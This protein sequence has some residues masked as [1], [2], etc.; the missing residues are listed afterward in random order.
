MNRE[1]V[2]RQVVSA[3]ELV[4]SHHNVQISSNK[5]QELT[6]LLNT[7]LIDLDMLF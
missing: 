5:L 1:V 4:I 3:N 7:E 6:V 2:K